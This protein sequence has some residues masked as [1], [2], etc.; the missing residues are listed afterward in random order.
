MKLGMKINN[1]YSFLLETN[2]QKVFDFLAQSP[3]NEFI[4]KE[5]QKST[6][7]SKPGVN[8]VLKEL[9]NKRFVKRNK[10]GR[11][12]FYK[13]ESTPLVK[14]WKILKNISLLLPLVNKLKE[15]VKKIILFGSWG[16]GD[17][18]QESDIDIFV[19]TN[20]SKEEIENVI[21]KDKLVKKIQLIIRTPVTFSKM[22][23]K[24]P[25]FFNEINKGIIIFE[26]KE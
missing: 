3:G 10:K 20:V 17:N 22:E 12:Y 25:I 23:E 7:V 19:L 13:V 6:G 26:K 1:F 2:S 8:L 24:D 18:D 5:I 21:K 11:M 9:T 14:Q 16:R 4:E 15:D